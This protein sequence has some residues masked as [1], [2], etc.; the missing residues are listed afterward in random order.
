MIFDMCQ[1]GDGR[2]V[3]LPHYPGYTQQN[4]MHV[5]TVQVDLDKTTGRYHTKWLWQ[6]PDFDFETGRFTCQMADPASITLFGV[7]LAEYQ[8]G[9]R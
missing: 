7:P 4:V 9:K 8:K 2:I 1:I 3:R 5:G 6:R